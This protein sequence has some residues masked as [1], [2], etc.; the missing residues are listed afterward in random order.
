M[1][2]IQEVAEKFKV[3]ADQVKQLKEGMSV[4]WDM[5]GHDCYEFLSSYGSE[6]EMIAEMT[7]DAGRLEEYSRIGG[8]ETDWKWLKAK[9]LNAIELGEATWDARY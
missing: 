1:P 3:T 5:I 8:M 4:T 2:T 7:I 9:G 6:T